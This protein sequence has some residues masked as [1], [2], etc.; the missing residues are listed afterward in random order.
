MARPLVLVA[1]VTAAALLATPAAQAAPLTLANPLAL[2]VRLTS[3]SVVTSA[4]SGPDQAT[5]IVVRPDVTAPRVLIDGAD[6]HWHGF[7]VPR[8]AQQVQ[9]ARLDGGGLAAW[10]AGSSIMVRSWDRDGTLQP[11][12]AVLTGVRTV[13]SVDYDYATWRLSS[14]SAGTVVIAAPTLDDAVVATIRDP[15]GDFAPAQQVRPPLATAGDPLAIGISAIAADG[16]VDVHWDQSGARYEPAAELGHAQR[17]GRAA[18]FGPPQPARP[19]TTIPLDPGAP[20]GADPSTMTTA[21]GISVRLGPWAAAVCRRASRGCAGATL[22]R[23]GNGAQVVA[24]LTLEPGGGDLP[25]GDAWYVARRLHDGFFDAPRQVTHDT[26][27][28]PIWTATPATLAFAAT[29]STYEDGPSPLYL[30]RSVAPARARLRVHVEDPAVGTSRHVQLNAW[31]S[32]S[33][34]IVATARRESH[35]RPVG[36]AYRATLAPGSQAFQ[37]PPAR[38]RPTIDAF[39]QATGLIPI[40]GGA[41]PAGTRVRLTLTVHGPGRRVQHVVRTLVRGGVPTAGA[42]RLWHVRPAR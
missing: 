23:W 21:E 22:F 40:H 37:L 6:G 18:T 16:S 42:A 26:A 17:D 27:A 36:R 14:D 35:G 38:R 9:L 12:Q 1:A 7:D 31:C 5:A 20:T 32:A 28:F 33:C 15:G 3:N 13:G 11:A 10:D 25:A 24:F 4:S 29:P 41:L 8:G 39:E 34:R 2:P 19:A 30:L